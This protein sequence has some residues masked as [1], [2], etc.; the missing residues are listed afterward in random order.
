MELSKLESK[1][2]E[3]QEENQIIIDSLRESGHNDFE[4]NEK[5]FPDE[6]KR[7]A[8]NKQELDRLRLE[9]NEL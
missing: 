2:Y 4:I 6:F 1:F 3:L 8:T 5:R 7:L 9:M